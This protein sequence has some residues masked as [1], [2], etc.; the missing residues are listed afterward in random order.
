MKLKKCKSWGFKEFSFEVD[1]RGGVKSISCVVCKEFYTKEPQELE[2]LKGAVKESTKSWVQGSS[3]IKKCNAETHLKSNVHTLAQQR[4][5]FAKTNATNPTP[6]EK[7]AKEKP[8]SQSSIVEHARNANA[9]QIK[10]LTKKFQLAHFLTVENKSFEF[11]QSLVRFEKDFHK[12]DLGTGYL[13]RQACHEMVI[14]LSKS[15]IV[16][17]ITEPLNEGVRLYFSLLFDG[18]SSAKTMDEK[19]VYIIKTCDKGTPRYDVLALEQPDDA[20]A[21]GLKKSLD[22]AVCKA[23]FTFDRKNRDCLLYTSPS[24]RDRTRSRMPSSA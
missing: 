5:K 16:E 20:D 18:S 11:Y 17:N 4:L 23:K 8:S 14:Y 22:E 24:P 12:V 9:K 19:E 10:E 13:N 7:I 2:K 6:A 3:R 1:E 15:L 21:L